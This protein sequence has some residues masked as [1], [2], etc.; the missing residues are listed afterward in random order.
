MSGKGRIGLQD[1]NLT[2]RIALAL[3]AAGGLAF[4]LLGVLV[5]RPTTEA[6]DGWITV[7][8]RV[9]AE[10]VDRSGESVIAYPVVAYV[11]GQGVEHRVTSRVGS[12]YRSAVGDVVAVAY[13]PTSPTDARVVGGI[14]SVG[15]LLFA[16]VGGLF[17][18]LGGLLLLGT[19]SLTK[20]RTIADVVM[21]GAVTREPGGRQAFRRS[22]VR[23][24]VNLYGELAL[25]VV[26]L[27]V[28][29]FAGLPGLFTIVALAIG[30]IMLLGAWQAFRR[31]DDAVAEVLENGL[32]TP[33]LG[34]RGWDELEEIRV[35]R[36][37]GTGDSARGYRRLGLVPRD[38]SLADARPEAERLMWAVVR[39]MLHT[40]TTAGVRVDDPAPFGISEQE[41]G[42]EAFE[43]LVASIGQ[44]H[45]VKVHGR[46]LP[47]AQ[48]TEGALSSL[49][50]A[51]GSSA[52]PPS[53]AADLRELLGVMQVFLMLG[54]MGR[55][56]GAALAGTHGRES[57]PVI[58][59][60]L[61]VS[62]MIAARPA[63]SLLDRRYTGRGRAILAAC[64]V[65]SVGV[66]II[67]PDVLGFR[68]AG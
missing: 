46:P 8:G 35:E 60:M 18:A 67:L 9:V 29:L 26:F 59:I 50:T 37:P 53:L 68:V 40:Y 27:F 55:F 61:I 16:G 39:P 14:A 21:G 23:E 28:G 56:A 20:G 5:V 34:F 42:Q 7:D 49:A 10:E 36:Y 25:G 11:D 6:P 38:T 15:W 64:A 66:G 65:L 24:W 32:V 1:T 51:A 33:D 45:E 57:L 12:S 52:H 48:I 2:G 41:I 54:I 19:F 13:D 47:M 3:F 43:R 4:L 63:R 44:H 62:L 22:R 58:G 31:R 17:A 30:G